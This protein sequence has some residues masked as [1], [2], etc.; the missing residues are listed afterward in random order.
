MPEQSQM[1]GLCRLTVKAFSV[2]TVPV[3]QDDGRQRLQWRPAAL[4]EQEQQVRTAAAV[5]GRLL[6]MSLAVKPLNVI[7]V[8]SEM[9][10]RREP[11]GSSYCL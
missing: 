1:C 10:I 8:H 11:A 2:L 6:K 3:S 7:S 5:Q 9:C 4:A